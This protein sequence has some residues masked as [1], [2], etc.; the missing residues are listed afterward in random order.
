[1]R[2]GRTKAVETSDFEHF[3][4]LHSILC[5]I[6]IMTCPG[7][8]KIHQRR[9]TSSSD[10]CLKYK[11][12]ITL[13]GNKTHSCLSGV[14]DLA[15]KLSG[16]ASSRVRVNVEVEQSVFEIFNNCRI[17]GEAGTLV[18]SVGE[19]SEDWGYDTNVPRA[20]NVRKELRERQARVGQSDAKRTVR[21]GRN[22]AAP[23]RQIAGGVLIL[24]R[25][26]HGEVKLLLFW[27]K[28]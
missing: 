20:M 23:S 13:L 5:L 17:E 7:A 27:D 18:G 11:L 19:R 1:M 9:C 26:E 25:V 8:T 14:Q 22:R 24:S 28:R 21:Q 3:R 10:Q 15:T 16:G 4:S 2:N 6:I 12:L